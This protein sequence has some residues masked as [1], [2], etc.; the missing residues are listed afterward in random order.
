MTQTAAAPVIPNIFPVLQYRDARKAI[1]WL[2]AT[3]GFVSEAEFAAPDGGIAHANL[4]LGAGIIGVSSA[5]PVRP[6]NPWSSVRSGVYVCVT[7]PDARHARAVAAG[8]PIVR[9][10]EDTSY[11]SR[12]FTARDPGGHL[13]AFGTYDMGAKPGAPNIF[14]RLHYQDGLGAIAF[15]RDALGFEAGLVVPGDDDTI[16]RAEMWL[17][18][19]T[20]IIGS[21]PGA[22]RF[23]GDDRQSQCVT[24]A[25]PDAHCD[26]ARSAGATIVEPPRDTPD[27]S[28]GYYVRDPEG[29]V[30]EF[31]TYMPARP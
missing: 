9:P 22:Q 26:R 31:T 30:W 19:G 7:D 8:A 10:L 12:D 17:G 16:G 18:G 23:V 4:R 1:D 11:G 5:G 2:I 20:V 28:R 6:E 24:V 27:G 29:F 15:V 25:D 21:A 13:W 3:F 14:V